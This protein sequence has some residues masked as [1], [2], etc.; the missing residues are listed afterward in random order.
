MCKV[1]RLGLT[2]WVSQRTY[3]ALDSLTAEEKAYIAGVVDGEGDISM[4]RAKTC[5]SLRPLVRISNNSLELV[6]WLQGRFKGELSIG[7]VKHRGGN[8]KDGYSITVWGLTRC[9][10]FLEAI[11]P[12]LVIKIINADLLMAFCSRRLERISKCGRYPKYE[13][14]DFEVYDKLRALNLKGRKTQSV[15][16][17]QR[18]R[19]Q[20]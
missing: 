18:Q 5:T 11:S 14:S 9:L 8:R 19:V 1:H 6:N 20:V 4:N 7:I 10:R 2:K 15:Q 16:Q 3:Q 17:T 12:Y 13:T